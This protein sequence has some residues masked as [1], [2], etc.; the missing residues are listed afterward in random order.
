MASTLV[1]SPDLAT[2]PMA[3]ENSGDRGASLSVFVAVVVAVLLLLTGLVVD[4]GAKT[5]ADREAE[6]A[7]AQAARAGA[8]AAARHRLVGRDGSAAAVAEA[9]SSLA[10]HTDVSVGEVRMD[11]SGRLV[12]TTTRTVPTMFLGLIGIE[13]LTGH[14]QAEADL[15]RR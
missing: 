7:A 1:L 12:V 11:A 14:G 10:S 15:L 9:R 4:G 13:Q 6:V 8:D 2:T 5:A 3:A